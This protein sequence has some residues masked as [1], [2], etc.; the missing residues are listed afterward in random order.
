M[1]QC[2]MTSYDLHSHTT[3]SDGTLTPGELVKRAKLAGVDVLA[4]TDHDTT[5]ALL[6][7]C[8]AARSYGISVINGCEISVTWAG[9]T[10]HVLGFN[11]DPENARLQKGLSQIREHRDARAREIA[12]KLEKAGIPGAFTGAE[13]HS[14]GSLISRTH[15]A[16]FLAEG[17]YAKDVRS[18]FKHFLVKGKP[19][20][21]AGQWAQLGDVVDWITAA[22]GQAAIAHPARYK[23]T[24]TKLIRLIEEFKQAGGEGIEVVSGSHSRDECFTMA[25][26]AR[27]FDL[28]ASAGSDFHGPENPW[29]ELGRL[30]D[31]PP[32]CEPI[33]NSWH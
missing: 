27:D 20:F 6:P 32:G 13:K 1:I 28:L 3:A 5:E 17:G 12:L 22:G 31:L 16:H 8:M 9:I 26:H 30:P 4:I 33:W 10:V 23:L 11:V 14:K 15:F 18:V 25:K 21:V 24:R 19:G 29:V 7:A 2:C